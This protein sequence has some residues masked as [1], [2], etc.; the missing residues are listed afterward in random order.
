MVLRL[1]NTPP[2]DLDAAL[3]IERQGERIWE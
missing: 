2:L 3:T 1:P